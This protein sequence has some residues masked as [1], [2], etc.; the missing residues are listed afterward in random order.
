[1]PGKLRM[2]AACGWGGKRHVDVLVEVLDASAQ[3]QQRG[4]DVGDQASGRVL[5]GQANGLSGRG[6]QGGVG[7]LGHP[8]AL[9]RDDCDASGKPAVFDVGEFVGPVRLGWL[10]Q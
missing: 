9:R 4:G 1:M 10:S 7:D 2:T 6:G 8:E 3:L 5:A